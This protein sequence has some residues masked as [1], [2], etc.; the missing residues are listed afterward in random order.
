MKK[1]LIIISLILISFSGFS[2]VRTLLAPK[3]VLIQDTLKYL[4]FNSNYIIA[5]TDSTAYFDSSKVGVSLAKNATHDSIQ[6]ISGSGSVLAAVKD[7]TGGGSSSTDTALVT[8]SSTGVII[9]SNPLAGR[10]GII[11]R[12]VFSSATNITSPAI[13]FQGYYSAVNYFRQYEYM[14]SLNF[15][16]SPD[17]T[18]WTTGMSINQYGVVTAA[19]G[20]TATAGDVQGAKFY[21]GG[22]GYGSFGAVLI[23]GSTAWS[24]VP[25]SSANYGLSLPNLSLTNRGSYPT[26]LISTSG[27]ISN[28]GS[29]YTNGTYSGK[30]FTN[31]S[32][33]GSGGTASFTVSGGAITSVT[34]VGL[35]SGYKAGDILSVASSDVGGTGSGFT[36]TL[37]KTN[38]DQNN[39]TVIYDS[40]SSKIVYWDSHAHVNR[41]LVDS[42]TISG[43][44]TTS[45]AGTLTLVAGNDYV[46]TGTTATYTLPAI[47][48]TAI[49]RQNR[50]YIKNRGSGT[51]TLNSDAGTTIYTTSAVGTINI[52]AGAACELLPDGTYFNVMYN[53]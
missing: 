53:N 31:V 41:P 33:S 40:S 16:Y 12:N 27:A 52:I 5:N 18:T 21:I 8:V 2:Q 17:T 14:R 7:S 28:G 4:H 30:P 34:G 1:T 47:S 50:I 48:T 44:L 35:G 15:D 49:G 32:S 46:A 43:N 45:S 11:L 29:G 51:I 24:F 10:K 36:F 19:D 25:R 20:F 37:T 3:G 6:L 42:I 13:L 22:A 23:P 39:G 9:S 26:M 38:G